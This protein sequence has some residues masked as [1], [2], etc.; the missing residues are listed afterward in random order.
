MTTPSKYN[1]KIRD[2]IF[3]LL[4][5]GC[6]IKDVCAKV[7]ISNVSFNNWVNRYPEFKEGVEKLSASFLGQV[8]QGMAMVRSQEKMRNQSNR[9]KLI[10]ENV[11]R[12]G[13][14]EQLIPVGHH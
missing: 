8:G 13:T 10:H 9:G 4:A 2:E 11:R 7:N 14:G 6:L 1:D 5:A 12:L 3:Q